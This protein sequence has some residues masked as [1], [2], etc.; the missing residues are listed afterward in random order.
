MKRLLKILVVA[1]LSWEAKRV[2][3]KHKPFI[4]AVTGSVGKTSTKD[5]IFEVV[6]GT[7]KARKSMKSFNSELGVPLTILGLENKWSSV[8]GWASNIIHGFFMVIFPS[9][10]PQL[11][12]LEVG[13]DHPGDIKRITAWLTPDITVITRI[14]DLPV[15]VEYFSS[16]EEVKKEKSE[17]VKALKQTGVFIANA[18]DPAVVGLSSLTRAHMITYGFGET[19]M[20]RGSNPEIDYRERDDRL[21]PIGMKYNIDYHGRVEEV[22]LSGILGTHVAGATLAAAA[23]GIAR[24]IPLEKII[25]SLE[26]LET[27]RGRMRILP[28]K[29]GSTIIDDSYNSSP[30]ALKA[31]LETLKGVKANHR[32]AVLGDMLELGKYSNTEHW[33]I[34]RELGAWVDQLVTVGQRARGIAEG[35]KTA[36]LPEGKIRTFS[37]S[38]EAGKWLMPELKTGDV[39][40]VKGS[41]GSGENM[42]R[43]ERAVK[44]MMTH[45]E[46]ADKYL[47]RQEKEWLNQYK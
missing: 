30:V 44:E 37:N 3:R 32:I 14:P 9:R 5:A 6:K 36:G 11:L 7:I 16:P 33:D 43:M 21:V 22:K 12:V 40:L 29:S 27:P 4:I 23:V 38:E 24:N 2:L 28:G 34:G 19:A 47:V 42:V 20:V 25:A 18:D 15:H 45:P 13:A 41:Q 17:L 10:Y 26:V 35:A 8:F 46:D 31:A 1:I 39:V